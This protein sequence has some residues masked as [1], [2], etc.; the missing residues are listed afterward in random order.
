VTKSTVYQVF[1]APGELL[2]FERILNHDKVKL[3]GNER[4]I[5]VAPGE[6]YK[7]VYLKQEIQRIIREHEEGKIKYDQAGKLLHELHDR[8]GI[9]VTPEVFRSF[10]GIS[11]EI[12]E[13]ADVNKP[14]MTAE[15]Q[16]PKKLVT[17]S[18][19]VK[20]LFGS[21]PHELD[22]LLK[23]SDEP[24]DG[25]L[26][27]VYLDMI[28]AWDL[29]E[30]LQGFDEVTPKLKLEKTEHSRLHRLIDALQ[31]GRC[32]TREGVV[33]LKDRFPKDIQVFIVC[34]DWGRMLLAHSDPDTMPPTDDVKLPFDNC[35]FEMRYSGRQ[36]IV[37]CLRDQEWLTFYEA[38]S[39]EWLCLGPTKTTMGYTQVLGTLTMLEAELATHQ[40]VRQPAAL[41][42]KRVKNNK[43]PLFDYHVVD[44]T[45]RFKV[46]ST[47]KAPGHEP[48]YHLRWHVV[49]GHW[50]TA[51]HQ[52][53]ADK[54]R[55]AIAQRWV[56][57]DGRWRTW[58]KA[59]A[60]GDPDLGIIEKE[61]RL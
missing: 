47:P 58:I 33:E 24:G 50:L 34:H 53:V 57:H 20:A 54:H 30:G 27:D 46:E 12:A 8:L 31:D 15:V 60:R 26:A 2:R 22:S 45:T 41:N 18:H 59:F 51:D 55:P 10:L 38:K 14:L 25:H 13:Q 21:K 29:R 11:R 28:Q 48:A 52:P 42:A 23:E 35:V 36:L 44:L 3:V 9:T 61:Y 17:L 4:F 16:L 43:V 19:V 6:S 32:Y 56:A 40:V 37:L 39:Q 5:T 49:R 1:D 7:N